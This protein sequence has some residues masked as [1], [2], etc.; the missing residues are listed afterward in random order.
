MLLH[1]TIY[2][3]DLRIDSG[4]NRC[5]FTVQNQK[6]RPPKRNNRKSH[7]IFDKTTYIDN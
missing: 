2:Y 4:V 3:S 7:N 6:G 1:S 5:I